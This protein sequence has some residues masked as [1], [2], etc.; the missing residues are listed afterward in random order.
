MCS[1]TPYE[2]ILQRTKHKTFLTV[3]A[4]TVRSRTQRGGLHKLVV[5]IQQY[6]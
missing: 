3:T 1:S 6:L 5:S 2:A 4:V